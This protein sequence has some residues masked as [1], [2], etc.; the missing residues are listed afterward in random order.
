[1]SL[2]LLFCILG[3]VSCA[4]HA[5]LNDRDKLLASPEVKKWADTANKQIT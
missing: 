2:G 5:V 1:M 3:A 4:A